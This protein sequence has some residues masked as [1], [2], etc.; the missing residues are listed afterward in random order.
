MIPALPQAADWV[1]SLE[2]HPQ[3]VQ[4]IVD[5]ILR[6]IDELQKTPD[7]TVPH[8]EAAPSKGIVKPEV[9]RTS[10]RSPAVHFVADPNQIRA[11]TAALL[12]YQAKLGAFA[13]AKARLQRGADRLH[14]DKGEDR[15][16]RQP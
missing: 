9:I 13:K 7:R 14:Q 2:K 11:P 15:K 10:L 4:T 6:A 12:A 5:A 1:W 3:Q 8:I 16:D